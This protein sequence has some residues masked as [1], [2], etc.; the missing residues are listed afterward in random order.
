MKRTRESI[1]VRLERHS[2]LDPE[3]GCIEWLGFTQNGYGRVHGWV[4][5]NRINTGA[6]RAAW[7]IKNGAIPEGM[8]VCHKCDNRRCINLE[9]LWLGTAAENTHDMLRKN[10]TNNPRK[11]KD[12]DIKFIHANKRIIS[13]R[14]LAKQFDVSYHAIK[15]VWQGRLYMRLK[16]P[17][18]MGA[19]KWRKWDKNNIPDYTK[20]VLYGALDERGEMQIV[21]CV[22]NSYGHSWNF[23][24]T[25]FCYINAIRSTEA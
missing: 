21:A 6:H 16:P 5:E 22:G 8:F 18:H 17:S 20:H 13:G 2:E 19:T 25:H 7:I 9:H 14:A 3:T 4:G 12:A 1:A 15:Q 23:S 10:R 11:L 24:P